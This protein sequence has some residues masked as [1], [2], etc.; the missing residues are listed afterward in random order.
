MYVRVYE[1]ESTTHLPLSLEFLEK[2]RNRK[3]K[4]NVINITIVNTLLVYLE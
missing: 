3:D 1:M 2:S 4:G